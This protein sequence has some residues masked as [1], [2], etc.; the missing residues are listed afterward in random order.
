MKSFFIYLLLT[1]LT[2]SVFA[3][4]P[5]SPRPGRYKDLYLKSAFT[6]P[7]EVEVG[8]VKENDLPDWVLVALSKYVDGVKVKLMNKKD[9]SR[10]T[11]PS[12]EATELGFSIV[13]VKQDRN[14][15]DEAVVTV[16]KNGVVGKIEF[17]P[18]FLILKKVGGGAPGAKV[19]AP[20]GNNGKAPTAK[21]PPI[22][23]RTNGR[24]P[25]GSKTPPTP[26]SVPRPSTSSQQKTTTQGSNQ[27]KRRPRYPRKK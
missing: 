24:T 18:Q 21:R 19:P 25:G 10:V 2:G 20:A 13:E 6:D 27:P 26:G 16:R 7:P 12:E 17:D 23:G 5:S 1:V 4:L 14:F 3:D 11:I 9:R 15:I 22:P 8:P